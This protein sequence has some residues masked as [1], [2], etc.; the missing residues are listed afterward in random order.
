VVNRRVWT[1]NIFLQLGLLFLSRRA[2]PL[3]PPLR[4]PVAPPPPRLRHRHP[5]RP[6]SPPYARIL[7]RRQCGG[8]GPDGLGP[9]FFLAMLTAL[10][11]VGWA[12]ARW[13][14]R[15]HAHR[16]SWPLWLSF[17]R[18]KRSPRPRSGSMPTSQPSCSSTPQSW[19][20]VL[21]EAATGVPTVEETHLLP[22]P[23]H[24]LAPLRP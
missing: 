24:Q 6:W 16:M 7:H 22:G 1:R 12:V 14:R 3:L 11:G 19:G 2:S 20:S 23:A 8:A 21:P 9:Y 18:S 5:P 15:C 17:W 10:R 4:R 13:R